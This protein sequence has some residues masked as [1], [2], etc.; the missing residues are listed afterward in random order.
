MYVTWFL[1]C[2]YQRNLPCILLTLFILH[3]GWIGR[4]ERLVFP[5]H[6]ECHR[7]HSRPFISLV[8]NQSTVDQPFY[9]H[10]KYICSGKNRAWHNKMKNSTATASTHFRSHNSSFSIY[11]PQYIIDKLFCTWSR[12]ESSASDVSPFSMDPFKTVFTFKTNFQFF[13][14]VHFFSIK[15]CMGFI[16]ICDCIT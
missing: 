7:Q 11:F 15:E 12:V 9:P 6:R 4:S 10:F 16:N 2:R 8:F 14:Y 5:I 3:G 1:V 13:H